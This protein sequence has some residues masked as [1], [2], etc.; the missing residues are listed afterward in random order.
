MTWREEVAAELS[1]DEGNRLRPY[2]DTNKRITI[3]RGRNLSSKGISEAE[4]EV[5][6]N[7]DLDDAIHN[8][9]TYVSGWA[10]LDPVRQKA[11]VN[12]MFNLGWGTFQLFTTFWS[13]MS[14]GK[15]SAAAADL[16][17]TLW[18]HQIQPSRVNRILTQLI[19]GANDAAPS[20]PT[21]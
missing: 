5:L 9:A 10:K 15:Y 17:T 11:I 7:N 18:A 13:L 20:Q 3:G 8:C 16:S 1:A 19:D 12:L 14:Q 2:L 21:A 6:F 4:S